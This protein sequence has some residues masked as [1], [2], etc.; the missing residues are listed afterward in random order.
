MWF[1]KVLLR[2]FH[3]VDDHHLGEP[4][5]SLYDTCRKFQPIVDHANH[6]SH[7][8]YTSHKELCVDES[9]VGTKN[10]TSLM[11]YLPNKHHRDHAS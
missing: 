9:L 10:H 5:N 6:V 2:F 11:Q 4:E 7:H 1:S 3:M 8:Y